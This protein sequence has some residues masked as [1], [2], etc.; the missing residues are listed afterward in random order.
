MVEPPPGTKVCRTRFRRTYK[1]SAT[2]ETIPKSRFLVCETNDGRDV[3]I[4]TEMP[5]AWIRRLLVVLSLSKSWRAATI[6]IKTAF[7]L[8]PLP[9][10]HGEVYIRLPN[11]LPECII[12]TGFQP[13]NVHKLNKSLYGLKESPRLFNDFLAKQLQS[14]GW[15]KVVGGVF[16]RPDNSG[17]LCA[18]VDDVLCMSEDPVT[19]LQAVANILK[20][21]DLLEVNEMAQRH[22]GLEITA[23]ETSFY[24]DV[25]N[26]IQ[27]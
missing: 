21:S 4:S 7:L 18:Y 8:V 11:H 23:T 6:D 15:V 19:D 25:N 26:Y 22:V 17:F 3:E 1:T 16:I 2:L 10:E 24:F 20:C 5:S 14:L 13:G 12:H 9:P 27:S